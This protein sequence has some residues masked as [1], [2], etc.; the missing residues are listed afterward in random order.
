[1]A[2][3]DRTVL[4][5]KATIEAKLSDLAKLAEQIAALTALRDQL[6]KQAQEAAARAM[7]DAQLRA[8]MAPSSPSEKNLGASAKAQIALLNRQVGQTEGSSSRRWPRRSASPQRPMPART[9][10]SPISARG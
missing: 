8:A 1:M 3:L 7:T 4:A 10:R 9:C 5:N 6:E 2:E